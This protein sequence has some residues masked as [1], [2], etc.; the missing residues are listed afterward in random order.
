MPPVQT[1]F[2]VIGLAVLIAG[3]SELFSGHDGSARLGIVGGL[4]LIVFSEWHRW[5]SKPSADG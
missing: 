5:R 4:A 3:C 1:Y 2:T